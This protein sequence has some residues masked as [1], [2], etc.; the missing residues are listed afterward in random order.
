VNDKR[1]Y[2]SCMA[3]LREYFDVDFPTVLSVTSTVTVTMALGSS[4]TTFQVPA[5][6]HYHFE[7]GTKYISY[8]VSS[9]PSSY[10][11]GVA[12]VSNPQVPLDAVKGIEARSGYPGE[13]MVSTADLK[14]SGRIFL[15][16]EDQLSDEQN[17]A[18]EQLAKEK[19]LD[20]V[21]RNPISAHER[22]RLE[23]PFA[24]ICHDWRDKES[25]ARPIAI[26]LIKQRCPVW[27][28]EY[29]LKVGD[30]LRASVEK[31]L[32]ESKKCVLI[33]SS[34]FLSNTGWTKREFDSIFTREILESS[35]VVLPV[36]SGV[37][38]QQIFE[39]SPSLLDRL[40]VQWDEGIDEVLRKLNRA[41]EPPLSM[42]TRVDS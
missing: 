4:E 3:T 12:L 8:F 18:L 16:T 23:K 42:Y 30:S 14:F 24:F 41:I 1:R 27:Y 7:S 35:N 21:L 17:Q 13:R 15:Y 11:L 6:V 2:H 5:R 32:K 37:T 29:S 19:G 28:D 22:S 39:Y 20:M 10:A 33:L 9:G 36:W 26:G 34:N 25:I 31:G 38:K 40:A